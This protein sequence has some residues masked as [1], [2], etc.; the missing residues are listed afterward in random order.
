[1]AG[2]GQDGEGKDPKEE[3]S[4]TGKRC[5]K[6]EEWGRGSILAGPVFPA[7]ERFHEIL[8]RVETDGKTAESMEEKARTLLDGLWNR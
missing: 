7:E 5:M 3:P 1:M 2:A 4:P 6:R 8:R